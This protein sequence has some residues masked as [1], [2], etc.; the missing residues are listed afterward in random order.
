[1]NIGDSSV[2]ITGGSRGLGR[3]IGRAFAKRGARVVLVARSEKELDDAVSEIRAEGGIAH[4]LAFDV[5]A[6][7]AVH[8]IAG[9]AAALVGSPNIVVHAAS[10]LGPL[11]MP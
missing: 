7:Q 8:K 6:K 2:L 10:T 5:G 11:P 9:A 4:G 1:M 3:A